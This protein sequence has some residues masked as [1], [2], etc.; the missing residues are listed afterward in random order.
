MHIIYP[1]I[2]KFYYFTNIL[3]YFS[4]SIFLMSCSQFLIKN[5]NY[6]GAK[7][8]NF[9]YLAGCRILNNDLEVIRTLS[10]GYLCLPLENGDWIEL[11]LRR[12]IY[13]SRNGEIRWTK[14]GIFHHQIKQLDQNHF[15]IFSAQ[16]KKMKIGRVKFDSVLKIN[17]N[18]GETISRFSLFDEL[19]KTNLLKGTEFD[20]K[21]WLS[22]ADRIFYDNPKYEHTH[23]NSIHFYKELIVINQARGKAF[24]LTHDLKF[25]EFFLSSAN[26]SKEKKKEA[27]F[28]EEVFVYPRILETVLDKT[29]HDFQVLPDGSYLFFKNMNVDKKSEKKTFKIFHIKKNQ[30]IIFEY[31]TKLEDYIESQYSGGVEKIGSNYLFG[32]P[33]NDKSFVG[34][35]TSEGKLIKKNELPFKIQDIRKMN[36]DNYLDLNSVR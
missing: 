1:M 33:V 21:P 36:Y 35:V 32:F 18:S 8:N 7:K 22:G 11:N 13:W 14:N 16:I 12:L 25:K 20:R 30:E 2:V 28:P 23:L 6:Q 19:Y 5:A 29:S 9:F 34:L 26:I 3:K 10:S 24:A 31:P 17:I 27:A 4:I 15:I